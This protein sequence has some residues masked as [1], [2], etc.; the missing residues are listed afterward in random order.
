MP[1][2]PLPAHLKLRRANGKAPH[3][4]VLLLAVL[5]AIEQGVITENRIEPTADLINLFNGYWK[6]LVPEGTFQRRFFL[7]FYH[8]GSDVSGIW[9][10]HALPG[11]DAAMTK[12]RSPKSLSSLI[13]FGVWAELREDVYLRWQR[14]ENTSYDRLELI[15]GYFPGAAMPEALPDHL[16]DLEYQ[17]MHLTREEYVAA[18][19]QLPVDEEEEEQ[20]LRSNA[21]KRT[22]PRVY[23]HQCAITGLRI[24]NKDR[25]HLIDACHIVPWADSYDDTVGNGIALSPTMHRAFDR[26][27]IT[28]AHD[29][30]VLVSPQ[31]QEAESAH[32]IRPFAGKRL[33]LPQEERYMPAQENL[34]WHRRRWGYL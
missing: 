29:H 3:K 6:V 9:K 32:A 24:K 16:R 27:L 2:A 15:R 25:M 13:H 12:S 17:M 10:V 26:G 30:T 19:L 34:A 18:Q 8:L 22:I 20:L 28:I 4:P 31:L 11:F 14:P 23:D 5:K 7:P 21:F 33:I 1:T